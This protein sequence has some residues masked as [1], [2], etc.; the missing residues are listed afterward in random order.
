VGDGG[1]ENETRQMF[2]LTNAAIHKGIIS[3]NS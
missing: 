1:G 3:S 2:K